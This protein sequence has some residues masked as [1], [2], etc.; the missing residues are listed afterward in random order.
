M[1]RVF[2]HSQLALHTAN[3]KNVYLNFVFVHFSA[4]VHLKNTLP[5]GHLRNQSDVER[6]PARPE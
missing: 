2:G 6:R 4:G 5:Q 1:S 3:V